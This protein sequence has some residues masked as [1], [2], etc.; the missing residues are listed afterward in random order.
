MM[1]VCIWSGH[2]AVRQK[3]ASFRSGTDAILEVTEALKK[4]TKIKKMN[5]ENVIDNGLPQVR[6]V[7]N[8]QGLR[9]SRSESSCLFLHIS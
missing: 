8:L 1:T 9:E 5:L 7:N 2:A 4:N 6:Q 3:A